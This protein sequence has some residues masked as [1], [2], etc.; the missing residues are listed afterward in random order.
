[1]S[2]MVGATHLCK[3]TWALLLDLLE[4]KRRGT[5]AD[6]AI[7]CIT[8]KTRLTGKAGTEPLWA[9]VLTLLLILLL[10]P[11]HPGAKHPGGEA[12]RQRQ[13]QRA[14]STAHP[15]RW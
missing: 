1:M 3:S 10:A 2:L 8:L 13:E 6:A 11:P 12:D 4:R 9:Q 15:C 5:L 7:T 14:G